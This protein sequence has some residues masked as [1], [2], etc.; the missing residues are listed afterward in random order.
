MMKELPGNRS[1]EAGTISMEVVGLALATPDRL[2]ITVV[3]INKSGV[4]T[5]GFL[6]FLTLTR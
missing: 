6:I 4:H 1:I 2:A 5:K 3:M